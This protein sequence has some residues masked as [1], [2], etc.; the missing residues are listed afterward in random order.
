MDE[1]GGPN[2]QHFADCS[3][4][5]YETSP[6]SLSDHGSNPPVSPKNYLPTTGSSFE[7]DLNRFSSPEQR[8]QSPATFV[9]D[10]SSP[11]HPPSGSFRNFSRPNSLLGSS[12][13][14][15][16]GSPTIAIRTRKGEW[17]SHSPSPACRQTTGSGSEQRVLPGLWSPRSTSPRKSLPALGSRDDITFHDGKKAKIARSTGDGR[18]LSDSPKRLPAAWDIFDADLDMAAQG[19]VHN[20]VRSSDSPRQ[21]ASDLNLTSGEEKDEEKST[22]LKER[23]RGEQNSEPGTW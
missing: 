9:R 11:A 13:Q 23:P 16:S 21:T 14:D 2:E 12:S 7:F 5:D 4:S 22:D 1:N 3:L 18:R 6:A 15:L 17:T 8:S 10:D 20:T 19:A